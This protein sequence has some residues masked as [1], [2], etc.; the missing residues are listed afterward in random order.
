MAHARESSEVLDSGST[1]WIPIP[2]TG[3]QSLSAELRFWIP[4]VSEIQDSTRKIRISLHR[5]NR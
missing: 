1:P 4:T 5:A 3:F 2:G